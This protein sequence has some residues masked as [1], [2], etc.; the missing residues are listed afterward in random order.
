VTLAAGGATHQPFLFVA[1]AAGYRI[2][3][4]QCGRGELPD[5]SQISA[6]LGVENREAA[7]A[8]AME[9]LSN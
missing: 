7:A 9:L 2:V 8:T 5:R 1:G 3:S 4:P 6:K